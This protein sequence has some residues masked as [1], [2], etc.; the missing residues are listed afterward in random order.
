MDESD[1][2]EPGADPLHDPSVAV[3]QKQTA[4]RRRTGLLR[5]GHDGASRLDRVCVVEVERQWQGRAHL[6]IQ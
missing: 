1:V 6:R 5:G 4:D 2:P 3:T